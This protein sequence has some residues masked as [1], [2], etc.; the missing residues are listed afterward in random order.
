M[1]SYL[2]TLADEQRAGGM[3]AVTGV[4]GA[5]PEPGAKKGA[6]KKKKTKAKKGKEEAESEPVEPDP[7]E[8]EPEPEPAGPTDVEV[9]RCVTWNSN[10]TCHPSCFV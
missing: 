2:N 8:P 4:A 9:E 6:K 7:T 5:V 10:S 1:S 3:A